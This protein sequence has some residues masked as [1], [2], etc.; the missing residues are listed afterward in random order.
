MCNRCFS[1]ARDDEQLV[2]F[3]LPCVSRCIL[4]NLR[5]LFITT[6]MRPQR[7]TLAP[8]NASVY[9]LDTVDEEHHR[10]NDRSSLLLS[11]VAPDYGATLP[12]SSSAP[13]SRKIVFNALL[14]MAC[15]FLLSTVAL[16]GTLW[17]A[18]PTLDP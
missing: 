18:L 3:C 6:M 5:S 16:G 17:L 13:S 9:T 1:T 10:H 8:C 2:W 11:P 14:K 7:P 4:H 15:I 12:R